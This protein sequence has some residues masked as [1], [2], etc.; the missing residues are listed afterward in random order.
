MVSRELMQERREA[1][2]TS[3]VIERGPGS[4]ACGDRSSDEAPVSWGFI[5]VD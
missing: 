4:G 5:I 2:A 1:R 3:L